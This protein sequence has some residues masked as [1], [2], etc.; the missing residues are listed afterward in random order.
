MDF[1]SMVNGDIARFLPYHMSKPLSVIQKDLGVKHLFRLNASESPFGVSKKVRDVLASYEE[2]MAYFPDAHAYE[3]KQKLKSIYGY[4]VNHITVGADTQE[5]VSLLCRAFLNPD[6]NVIIPQLSSVNLE[7]SAQLSGARIITTGI[8]DDWTA[9]LDAVLDSINERTRMV[10]ISNPSNPLGAFNV[11]TDL[12]AFMEL[13]PPDVIVVLDEELI[14]FLGPGYRDL[15]PLIVAHPNLLVLRS[16]SHAYGLASLRIGYMLS[17]EEICGLI[18]VLRDP[19]NVSQLALDCACAALDDRSFVKRV[20]HAYDVE[21]NRFRDFCGYYGLTM[22]NTRTSSVTIDFGT[23]AERYYNALVQLGIF[24]RP[25]SYLGLNTLINISMGRPNVTDYLLSKL[26][27]FIVADSQALKAA[28]EEEAARIVSADD[29]DESMENSRSKKRRSIAKRHHLRSKLGS[30][31]DG[32]DEQLLAEMEREAAAKEAAVDAA[33]AAD[34]ADGADVSHATA[35][36]DAASADTA[37]T[38]DAAT[39]TAAAAAATSTAD[40]HVAP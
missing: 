6:V 20:V 40:T 30:P 25:L 26:E 33:H 15:Y 29:S 34:G 7:R 4:N 3:L 8:M 39:V 28:Q 36:P 38:T 13:V 32:S 1:S 18:N 31:D 10:L 5:L 14:D 2:R 12:E 35:V 27:E 9:D 17:G 16:F 19:Y 22:L 11:Y 23:Q 21:R 37:A 24:T